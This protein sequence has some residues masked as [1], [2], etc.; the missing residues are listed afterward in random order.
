MESED[1]DD[2]E[3]SENNNLHNIEDIEDDAEDSEQNNKD[4]GYFDMSGIKEESKHR[5]TNLDLGMKSVTENIL[6]LM[7]GHSS[8]RQW[9]CDGE[10]AQPS[11]GGWLCWSVLLL[12]LDLLDHMDGEKAKNKSKQKPRQFVDQANQTDLTGASASPPYFKPFHGIIVKQ[13]C[14]LLFFGWGSSALQ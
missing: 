4:G 3:G 8:V 2:E 10:T 6:S 9:A 14:H 11:S 5:A 12:C 7:M 13:C 1:D